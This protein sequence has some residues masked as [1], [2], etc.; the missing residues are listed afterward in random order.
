MLYKAD[1]ALDQA[2]MAK[3]DEA[4]SDCEWGFGACESGLS[5][6]F[7][8]DVPARLTLILMMGFDR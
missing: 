7:G 4:F 6:T 8:T 1:P 5:V 3:S 2:L